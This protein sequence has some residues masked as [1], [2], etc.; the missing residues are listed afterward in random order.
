MEQEVL[1][2]KLNNYKKTYGT[3]FT[4]ISKELNVNRTTISLFANNKRKL[5]KTIY[6]RLEVYLNTRM[7]V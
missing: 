2:N 1:R 4:F 3:T 5:N 6:N 7:C